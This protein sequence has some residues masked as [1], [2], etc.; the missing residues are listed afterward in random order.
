[1]QH[2]ESATGG[3]QIIA[4]YFLMAIEF[5]AELLILCLHSKGH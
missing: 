3:E 4:Q 5:F 1:M 2:G